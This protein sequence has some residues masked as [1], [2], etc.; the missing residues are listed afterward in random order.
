MIQ[1]LNPISER[2]RSYAELGIK[3][4][5]EL[6]GENIPIDGSST[7]GDFCDGH[8]DPEFNDIEELRN[9]RGYLVSKDNINETF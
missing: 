8:F 1:T 3:T 5:A 6:I 2:L 9:I 7:P 4:L